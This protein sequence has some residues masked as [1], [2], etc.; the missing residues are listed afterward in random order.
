MASVDDAKRAWAR[1]YDGLGQEEIDQRVPERGA[2][3]SFDV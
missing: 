3:A 2:Y 1:S